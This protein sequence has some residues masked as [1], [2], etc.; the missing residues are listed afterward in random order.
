MLLLAWRNVWR[1][2]RRSLITLLSIGCGL[3]SILFGQSMLKSIQ[4]QLVRKATG[5]ITGH[6]QIQ[7]AGVKDLKIPEK[8]YGNIHDVEDLLDNH[9][10]V[11]DYSKRILFTG[12]VSSPLMSKGVLIC[13]VDAERERRIITIPNDIKEGRFLEKGDARHAVL[14]RKLARELDVRLGEKLVVMAQASDGSMGAELFRVVGIYETG[15]ATFDGQ[16]LYLPLG[17]VQTMLV[18]EGQVNAFVAKLKNEGAGVKRVAA[19]FAE[20]LK[21]RPDLAVQTWREIDQELVGIAKYQDAL[22]MIILVVIFTI[23]T[24]GILNTVLMS[25][26]ERVREFGVLMAIGA[27]PGVVRRLI[28]LETLILGLLG[29]AFGLALGAGLILYY[30]R[31]GLPLP[32]GDAINYFMPFDTV[33]YLRFSWPSHLFAVAM[34]FLTCLIAA[35]GPAMKAGRLRVAEALRHL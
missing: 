8:S 6:V 28:L 35:V 21:G 33:I 13:A 18:E 17:M 30:G 24:L 12:L 26:L 4:V 15:S 11:Q 22:L 3:A 10:D 23:V 2:R 20:K 32:M 31:Y 1:N 34:V 5:V 19:E 7:A 14:G 16:L 27:K 25:L 9:P 29:L